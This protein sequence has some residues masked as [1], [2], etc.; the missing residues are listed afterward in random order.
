MTNNSGR[1]PDTSAWIAR[2]GQSGYFLVA[3]RKIPS[4]GDITEAAYFIR[5]CEESRGWDVRPLWSRKLDVT[6]SDYVDRDSNI[7]R[8]QLALSDDPAGHH[9][10]LDTEPGAYCESA[11]R[12]F[13]SCLDLPASSALVVDDPFSGV[14]ITPVPALSADQEHA[15]TLSSPS[16][17][18]L[19]GT[20]ARSRP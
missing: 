5:P 6:R 13:D 2:P 17:R 11:C 12:P 16:P 14:P 15:R 19:R 20:P 10:S 1:R 9:G 4:G 18:G 3:D 8:A 7:R